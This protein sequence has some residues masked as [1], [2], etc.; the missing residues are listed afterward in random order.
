MI[1]NFVSNKTIIILGLIALCFFY[2]ENKDMIVGGLLGFLT[3]NIDRKIKL[4]FKR[5]S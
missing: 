5:K 4:P 1:N 2:P 3:D